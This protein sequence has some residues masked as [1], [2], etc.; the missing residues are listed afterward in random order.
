MPDEYQCPIMEERVRL[1]CARSSRMPS[2]TWIRTSEST[3]SKAGAIV[4]FVAARLTTDLTPLAQSAYRGRSIP[5]PNRRREMLRSLLPL[6]PPD[7]AETPH[8]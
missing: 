5:P 4:A 8:E 2:D 6:R 1:R 7:N 3:T